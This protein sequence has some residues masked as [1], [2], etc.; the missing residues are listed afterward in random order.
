MKK[1]LLTLIAVSWVFISSAQY[2]TPFETFLLNKF[3]VLDSTQLKFTYNFRYKKSD[4]KD[5]TDTAFVT[6]KQSLLIGKNIS[7]YYSQYYFDFCEKTFAKKYFIEVEKGACT[8]EIFKNISTNKITVTELAGQYLF[9]GYYLYNEEIPQIKWKIGKDTTS[10]MGYVCQSATTTFRRRNYTAWFAPEIPLNNGPWKF[11]GLPGLILKIYDN[12]HDYTFECTGFQQ[13]E[14]PEKIKLYALNYTKVTRKEMDK[15]YRR[16]LKDPI[17]FW[18][19][20]HSKMLNEVQ[21]TFKP[22]W[23]YNPIELE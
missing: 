18:K 9:G 12:K 8:F 1:L 20:I 11:G 13:L 17:Q 21:L 15:L 16:F 22:K 23:I 3:S 6:D 2:V 5:E 14:K 19:N 4:F 7:K 10:I